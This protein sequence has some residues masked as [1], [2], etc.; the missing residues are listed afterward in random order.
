MALYYVKPSQWHVPTGIGA[1][2]R[3]ETKSIVYREL[4]KALYF[5]ESAGWQR[6]RALSRSSSRYSLCISQYHG[7]GALYL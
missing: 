3:C 5:R 2:P 1:V 7:S 6:A 4:A